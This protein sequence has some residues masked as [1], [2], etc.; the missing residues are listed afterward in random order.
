MMDQVKR[1][2]EVDLPIGVVSRHARHEQNIKKGH[3][4]SFHVWS[5]TRPL[6]ACRAVTLAALLPHPVDE[7]CPEDS[8]P[9]G[10]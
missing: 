10:V 3:L 8:R 1:L 7:H 9:M 5:A 2:I 4:Y 6:A